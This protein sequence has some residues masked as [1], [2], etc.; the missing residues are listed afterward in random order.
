MAIVNVLHLS[1]DIDTMLDASSRSST[2]RIA[3][4]YSHASQPA[5]LVSDM[6]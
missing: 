6:N 4:Q 1:F 5:D 3:R 2:P